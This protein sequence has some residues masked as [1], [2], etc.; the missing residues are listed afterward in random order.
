MSEGSVAGASPAWHR[1]SRKQRAPR[2]H[3]GPDFLS[4]R[5]ESYRFRATNLLQQRANVLDE[6]CRGERLL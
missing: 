4:D 1:V 2:L 3:A 6:R 5:G